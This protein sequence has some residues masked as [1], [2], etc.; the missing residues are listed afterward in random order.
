VDV[1][2]GVG[3]A[4]GASSR[5]GGRLGGGGG[6]GAGWDSGRRGRLG[7][8]ITARRTQ[9]QVRPAQLS[10]AP[11]QERSRGAGAEGLRAPTFQKA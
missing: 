8:S 7:S 4:P 5:A 3:A 9:A 6:G 2:A 10:Q 11:G 1:G